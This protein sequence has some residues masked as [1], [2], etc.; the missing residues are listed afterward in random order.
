MKGTHEVHENWATT[1][2]KDCTV[3]FILK[4]NRFNHQINLKVP[5][6]SKVNFFFLEPKCTEYTFRMFNVR[7]LLGERD[8]CRSAS[9][10]LN[11]ASWRFLA[12]G[13]SCLYFSRREETSA[14]QSTE[15]YIYPLIPFWPKFSLKDK[16][17]VT[18]CVLNVEH[19][20][21]MCGFSVKK[22]IPQM[23]SKSIYTRRHHFFQDKNK[24]KSIYVKPAVQLILF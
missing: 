17:C 13:E 4:K 6:K 11:T 10:L 19:I 18:V 21:I 3:V 1:K 2:S 16:H 12:K 15:M 22:K 24:F 9:S 23:C 8:P 14:L 7:D 20:V 5:R